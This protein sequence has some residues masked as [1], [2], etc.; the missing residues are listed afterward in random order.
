MYNE[1]YQHMDLEH[2]LILTDSELEEII[3]IALKEVAKI[4]KQN[5]QFEKYINEKKA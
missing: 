4:E 3:N 5:D 2:G 1:L